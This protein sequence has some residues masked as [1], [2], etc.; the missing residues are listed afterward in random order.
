M[1]LF[2]NR[3]ENSHM[4]VELT[5]SVSNLQADEQTSH[6]EPKPINNHA[7][8]EVPKQ[9]HEMEHPEQADLWMW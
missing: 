5:E 7:Q 6:Q 4:R 1:V 8:S 2:K 3:R 9:C